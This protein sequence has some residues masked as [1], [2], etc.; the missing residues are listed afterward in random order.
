MGVE[1]C[2]K[3]D[4]EEFRKILY[5]ITRAVDQGWPDVMNGIEAA[6]QNAGDAQAGRKRRK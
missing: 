4:G 2:I 1:H 6:L 3:A 5:R